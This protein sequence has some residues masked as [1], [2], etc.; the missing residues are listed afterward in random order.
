[1]NFG[2]KISLRAKLE[3]SHN[4]LLKR[5]KYNS[6]KECR[7]C[8]NFSGIVEKDAMWC[9]IAGYVGT[10]SKEDHSGSST[11]KGCLQFRM[12]QE[13]WGILSI[14]LEMKEGGRYG[15]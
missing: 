11:P 7:S 4:E 6:F 9:Q 13:M 10:R 1:M 12:T 5:I 8:R 15:K 3:K 2:E 14:L